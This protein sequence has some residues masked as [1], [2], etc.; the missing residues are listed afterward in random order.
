MAKTIKFEWKVF[1]LACSVCVRRSRICVMRGRV[2][3]RL[4]STYIHALAVSS[5]MKAHNQRSKWWNN[6]L[7]WYLRGWSHFTVNVIYCSHRVR[8]LN[9]S[10]RFSGYFP[11]HCWL[12]H[13]VVSRYGYIYRSVFTISCLAC[14]SQFG[15]N[16]RVHWRCGTNIIAYI[17]IE[18]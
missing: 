14:V 18:C 8:S 15:C 9:K 2:C 3:V 10:L 7:V 16:L 11:I 6:I 1:E 4:L 17:R 5:N 12:Y 13:T